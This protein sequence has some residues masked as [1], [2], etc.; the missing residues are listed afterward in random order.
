MNRLG[1]ILLLT[2]GWVFNSFGQGLVPEYQFKNSIK[3]SATRFL[4]SE[5]RLTYERYVLDHK[6]S[7]AIS[8]GYVLNKKPG[9][10]LNQN[11]DFTQL[12]GAGGNIMIKYHP[13]NKY[14]PVLVGVRKNTV[15]SAY[16]APYAQYYYLKYVKENIEYITDGFQE[17]LYVKNEPDI[18]LISAYEGGIM[19][20]FEWYVFQRFDVE[21]QAGAGYRNAT[22]LSS[23]SGFP[24][25][26]TGYWARGFT[27]L[28][29]RVEMNLGFTF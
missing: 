26:S 22:I 18:D 23:G 7:I 5:Y 14:G 28:V 19:L 27:G 9:I 29:P 2:I 12:S 10:W 6:A 17:N 24:V 16:I 3:V 15:L 11:D 21:M 4:A 1:L 13:L 20:G 25:V 8:P